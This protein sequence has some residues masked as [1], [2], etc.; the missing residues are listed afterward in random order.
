MSSEDQ[1]RDPGEPSGT[2]NG[3]TLETHNA[4]NPGTQTV[5]LV[6]YEDTL[7]RSLRILLENDGYRVLSAASAQ[8]ALA[9]CTQHD[10]KINVLIA[11]A[12]NDPMI[13]YNLAIDVAAKYP[14]VC[15]LFT[16][17]PPLS[18]QNANC[19]ACREAVKHFLPKPY[20]YSQLRTRLTDLSFEPPGPLLEWLADFRRRSEQSQPAAEK[21]SHPKDK[22]HRV[23]VQLQAV[24]RDENLVV[25]A[26]IL[27]AGNIERPCLV[28]LQ[29]HSLGTWRPLRLKDFANLSKPQVRLAV[30]S[31]DKPFTP[32]QR[33]FKK[34]SRKQS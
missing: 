18:I 16:W 24:V 6:E 5:L 22:K 27:E 26:S 14:Q 25:P 9:I 19:D 15:V 3:S 29:I 17:N 2:S 34:S 31:T 20:L 21:S 8:S 11:N 7:A 1:A 28:E 4:R 10:G 33:Q 12:P 13:G 30:S 32:S 23:T